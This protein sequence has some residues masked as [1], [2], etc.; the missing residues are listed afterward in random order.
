MAVE[1]PFTAQLE[2]S[3]PRIADVQ[4][5]SY[6]LPWIQGQVEVAASATIPRSVPRVQAAI[7]IDKTFYNPNDTAFIEVALVNAQT[8]LPVAVT[9]ADQ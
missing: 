3:V 9:A 4:F 1:H 7:N 6:N 2:Q 8:K 5:Y